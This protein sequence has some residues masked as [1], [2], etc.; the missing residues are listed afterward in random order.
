[1]IF[2]VSLQ[3]Q[4]EPAFDGTFNYY[5]DCDNISLVPQELYKL[6][7]YVHPENILP[8]NKKAVKGYSKP[9]Q[10]PVLHIVSA[11]NEK[12][13]LITTRAVYA[14][15][16]SEACATVARFLESMSHKGTYFHAF[17]EMPLSPDMFLP[18][19]EE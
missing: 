13:H 4:A 7:Y 1:M 3:D 2:L 17:I 9:P 6:G 8:S 19:N 10:K 18:Q 5:I 12:H 15:R 14:L 16:E 11:Y